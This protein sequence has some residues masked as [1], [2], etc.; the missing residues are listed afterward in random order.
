MRLLGFRVLVI[1]IVESCC[2]AAN[3]ERV[4]LVVDGLDEC[5]SNATTVTELL[6]GLHCEHNETNINTLFLS[7]ELIE[8]RDC[9]K[10]YTQVAIAAQRSDLKLYVGA[11]IETRVRK[12]KLRIKDP[13]LKEYIMKQLVDGAQGMYVTNSYHFGQT[14]LQYR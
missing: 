14:F 13:S 11:E 9:L 10:A 4:T 8:I 2:M 1:A 5:G 6:V 3:F 7:R 12:K